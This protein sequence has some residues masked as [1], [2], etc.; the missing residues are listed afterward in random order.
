MCAV[1]KNLTN[2]LVI[3]GDYFL[4][5]RTYPLSLWASLLLMIVSALAGAFTD[6]QFD[7]YGYTWQLVNCVFTAAY[8]LYLRRGLAA[9][10]GAPCLACP[11]AF[12]PA[13]QLVPPPSASRLAASQPTQTAAILFLQERHGQG[14]PH[15]LE[16]AAAG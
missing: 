16:E 13:S 6:L 8:S 10:G 11:A 5:G 7:A 12:A 4:F 15:D 1:L 9:V 14:V 2:I 3:G